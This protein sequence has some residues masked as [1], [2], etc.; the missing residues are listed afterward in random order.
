MRRAA[1]SCSDR[2]LSA[3][4]F[5]GAL[6]TNPDAP[7]PEGF[8]GAVEPPEDGAE[9]GGFDWAAD[10]PKDEP[11]IARRAAASWSARSSAEGLAGALGT[12]PE[13]PQPEDLDGPFDDE[14][15]FHRRTFAQATGRPERRPLLQREQ[16]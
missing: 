5:E 1:N 10:F 15:E 4:C 6:G 7:Q 3:G 2:S 11:R 8:W 13:D 9:S 14:F 16:T 12:K